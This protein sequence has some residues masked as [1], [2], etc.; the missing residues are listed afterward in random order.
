MGIGMLVALIWHGWQGWYLGKGYPYNTFLC[1]PA[2]RFW[3]FTLGILG[4]AQ[5]SSPYGTIY[6]PYLPAT[7][8]AFR[9]FTWI[10]SAEA[11]FL[12]LSLTCVALMIA[13]FAAL[14]PAFPD[15]WWRPVCGAAFLL[16]SYPVWFVIDRANIELL[17]AV[18]VAFALLCFRRRRFY[19]GLGCLFPAVCFKLYPL[20]LTV[21]LVRPRHLIKLFIL[22][23]W[24]LA[25]TIVCLASF[26]HDF[27]TDL[28]L[29][30]QSL[31]LYNES[32]IIHN[33]GLAGSASPWNT[34]KGFLVACDGPLTLE[35]RRHLYHLY[36]WGAGSVLLLA[37]A[38]S[39]LIEREFF[40]R[41]VFLL[42]V[43]TLLVPSGSDYRLLYAG[44]ALVTQILLPTQRRHDLLITGLLAFVAV[45]KK[46][47]IL[48]FLGPTDTNC[49]DVSAAIF[50]NP[51]CLLAVVVLLFWDGVRQSPRRWMLL[52]FLGLI[53]ALQRLAFRITR[54]N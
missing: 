39:V 8:L 23:L 45:P 47:I 13:M 26:A 1:E 2:V 14:Q 19:L 40:R 16:L 35:F 42:L 24:F 34:L 28:G 31:S 32:Y 9:P 48:P 17:L 38:F 30:N 37:I 50:I 11:L 33:D 53:G 46:E 36:A 49:L 7:Y 54:A 10:N 15:K 44:M 41:A 25:V 5:V 12:F 18:L 6:S 43:M 4:F 52:R 27:K 20:L 29:L 21:L 22:P 3:D 51:P